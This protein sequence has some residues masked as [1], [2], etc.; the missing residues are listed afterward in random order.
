M[1]EPVQP[2][3]DIEAENI[4]AYERVFMKSLEAAKRIERESFNTA[5]TK[6]LSDRVLQIGTSIFKQFFT[7]QGNITQAQRNAEAM[8]RGISGV[9]EARSAQ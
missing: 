3:R 4:A 6:D 2:K 5:N 7:D 8:V 9:M 1:T